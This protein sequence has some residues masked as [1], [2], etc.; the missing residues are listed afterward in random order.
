MSLPELDYYRVIN[1]IALSQMHFSLCELS[2][3][4]PS[5]KVELRKLKEGR[6]YQIHINAKWWSRCGKRNMELGNQEVKH[7]EPVCIADTDIA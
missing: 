5:A 4:T 1:K 7:D 6:V 2:S 3:L